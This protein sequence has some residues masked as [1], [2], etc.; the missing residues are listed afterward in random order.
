MYA[1]AGTHTIPPFDSI[2]I[3]RKRMHR[4]T[5]SWGEVAGNSLEGLTE[6]L[7]PKVPGRYGQLVT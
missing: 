2:A 5:G 4:Y 6:E 7:V 1:K 3:L